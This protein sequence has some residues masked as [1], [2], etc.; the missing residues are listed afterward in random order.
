M[1]PGLKLGDYGRAR[2]GGKPRALE[3][4]EPRA[5]VIDEG[6]ELEPVWFPHRAAASLLPADDVTGHQD[7][8]QVR[9]AV[10]GISDRTPRWRFTE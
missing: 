4:L 7:F 6:I 2:R 1:P 9:G 10:V 8:S 3:A 5:S